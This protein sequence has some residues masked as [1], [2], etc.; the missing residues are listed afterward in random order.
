M[1]KIFYV[2]LIVFFSGCY[3]DDTQIL[4]SENASH[5]SSELSLK[6]KSMSAHHA[7]FDDIIDNISCF[8]IDFPYQINLNSNLKTIS[9]LEDI[10]EISA[11][12]NIEF[13]YPF[14]TTFYNYEEHQA[15][16]LTGFNLI[17]NTCSDE[18]NF[19][20]NP[21]LD[22]QF[23]ITLKEYNDLT[24]SFESYQ[25]DNDRDVYLHIENLHDNDI[26]EIVYPVFLKDSNANVIRVES[27]EQFISV[28]DSSIQ[29]CQQ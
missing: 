13:I 10:S 5:R 28:F 25:L 21:C 3:E 17:K 29:D 8:S 14:N 16:N 18:F 2:I 12:D 27:N 15:T 4:Q 22:F 7:A 20:P 11:E 24:E 9:S 1:K 23:P 6:I 26:Y 19:D